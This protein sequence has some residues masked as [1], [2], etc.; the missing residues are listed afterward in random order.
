MSGESRLF[1]ARGF[2]NLVSL[3]LLQLA[4]SAAENQPSPVQNELQ[5]IRSLIRRS[6]P[7]HTDAVYRYGKLLDR[8]D[9]TPEQKRTILSGLANSHISLKNFA[10]AVRVLQ[11]A[12][13]DESASTRRVVNLNRRLGETLRKSEKPEEARQVF[14]TAAEAAKRISPLEGIALEVEAFKCLTAGGK[15]DEAIEGLRNLIEDAQRQGASAFALVLIELAR[16]LA[17]KGEDTKAL[18][19]Y[20]R[21]LSLPGLSSGN[22]EICHRESGDIHRS[23]KRPEQAVAALTQLVI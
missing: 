16:T 18:E 21:L 22:R 1:R 13:E 7:R 8:D 9:L 10:D 3:T 6:S 14:I 2:L 23:N 5:A 12:L 11:Q 17:A 19:T 20:Q 15:T 4:P